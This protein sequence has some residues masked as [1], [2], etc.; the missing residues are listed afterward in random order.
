MKDHSSGRGAAAVN[1]SGPE[2]PDV[3]D[4]D[5]DELFP[6][7]PEDREYLTYPNPPEGWE[8]PEDDDYDPPYVRR[9]W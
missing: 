1:V 4:P 2:S 5:F 7:D 6:D 8:P 3:P 9:Y